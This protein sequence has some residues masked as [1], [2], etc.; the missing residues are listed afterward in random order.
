TFSNSPC[1][2][3]NNN[4]SDAALIQ[5]LMAVFGNDTLWNRATQHKQP[6]KTLGKKKKKASTPHI[7]ISNP[8]TASWDTI[9]TWMPF[10]NNLDLGSNSE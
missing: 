6:Y 5:D 8:I 10:E 9:S 4:D 1:E 2:V 3:E 7:S